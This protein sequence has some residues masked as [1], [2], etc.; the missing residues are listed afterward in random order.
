MKKQIPVVIGWEKVT[1]AI[2]RP[3]CSRCASRPVDWV[4]AWDDPQVPYF[5]GSVCDDCL[6]NLE[7]E[8]KP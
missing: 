6:V 7:K 1:P 4:A 2:N 5:A 8:K 3:L